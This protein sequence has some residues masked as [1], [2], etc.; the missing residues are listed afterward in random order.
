[1]NTPA[2]SKEERMCLG[3]NLENYPPIKTTEREL[4][5]RLEFMCIGSEDPDL[6]KDIEAHHGIK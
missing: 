4:L 6:Y 5:K 2:Y 3:D 1:M